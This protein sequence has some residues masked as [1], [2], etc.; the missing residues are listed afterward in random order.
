MQSFQEVNKKHANNKFL[1]PCEYLSTRL[2]SM[3]SAEV[4]G[5]FCGMRNQQAPGDL[6]TRVTTLAS[7]A[8]PSPMAVT[9]KYDLETIQMDA[10]N[11]F[12]HY[13]LDEVVNMG[14]PP[15]FNQGKRIRSFA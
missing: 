15:G 2:I 8:F 11:A 10:V 3:V 5:S 13:D 9:A 6:P 1:A 7:M 14:M 4:Q 12:V